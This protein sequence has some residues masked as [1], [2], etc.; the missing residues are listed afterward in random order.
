MINLLVG[1]VVSMIDPI[2]V[3]VGVIGGVLFQTGRQQFA[4]LI[5]AFAVVGL[6]IIAPQGGQGAV[7]FDAM[8]IVAMCADCA[9]AFA[10]FRWR[11]RAKAPTP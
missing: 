9:L 5:L 3:V 11:D 6:L 7:Y 2:L 4:W 10:F 1:V 8:Q